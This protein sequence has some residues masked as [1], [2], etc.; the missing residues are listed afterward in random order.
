MHAPQKG[1]PEREKTDTLIDGIFQNRNYGSNIVNQVAHCRMD[2]RTL[3][4][5]FERLDERVAHAE[6]G[7]IVVEKDGK[8]EFE[9]V[10]AAPNPEEAER[11]NAWIDELL[12]A[13]KSLDG[14][15]GNHFESFEH[16]LSTRL[17]ELRRERSE[18]YKKRMDQLR[19]ASRL[20]DDDDHKFHGYHDMGTMN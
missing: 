16:Q 7:V 12:V 3:L 10:A 11:L 1:S 19:E 9:S 20:K 15:E 8:K 2:T 14:T 17:H 6:G 13:T 18:E 5:I 4:R